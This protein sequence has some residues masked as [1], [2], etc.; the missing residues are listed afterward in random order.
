MQLIFH[1]AA[2][3]VGRSCIELKTQVGNFIFDCG[4]KITPDGFDYPE[5]LRDLSDV[6]AIFLSHAHLDHTGGLPL[7]KHYGSKAKIFCTNATAKIADILLKDSY[8]IDLIKHHHPAYTKYDIKSVENQM[9]YTNFRSPKNEYG[10]KYEFFNSGHIPGAS[11]IKL[12]VEGTD[13]LYTGDINTEET[14]LVK[15]A[16]T[17][18]GNVDIL[19]TES[20]YGGREHETRKNVEDKFISEIITT[21]RRGGS[22]VIP[23]F[24]VGRAQEILSVLDKYHFEVPVYLDGMAR[25]VTNTILNS[26]NNLNDPLKIRRAYRH[27]REVKNM[28]MRQMITNNQAIFLTTS[29][30]LSGG[31]IMSY[32][33]RFHNDEKSSVLLTGYQVEG[34]NGASLLE[35]GY[36]YIDGLKT[37][38]K[39]NYKQFDFSAHSGREELHELV[40]KINPKKI[41]LQHG[42]PEQIE[43][44]KKWCEDNTSISVYAPNINDIL[45]L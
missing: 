13:I 30:M 18:Y 24:G 21:L 45:E 28:K 29:G 37:K 36:V 16:D 40:K 12:T 3:E 38:V 31:P 9:V 41:I 32:L 43:E 35:T 27:V 7:L 23:V 1:G 44:F 19:I 5:K 42:D 25:K 34:T 2:K 15:S 20:T 17:D 6:K 26:S 14:E 22:V 8:Q 11:S 33:K 10:L 39:M 4:I